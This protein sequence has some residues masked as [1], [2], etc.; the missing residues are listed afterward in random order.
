MD[1]ASGTED[2][3]NEQIKQQQKPKV[4]GRGRRPEKKIV[5]KE[6]PKFLQEPKDS[7]TGVLTRSQQRYQ[8]TEVDYDYEFVD[9]HSHQTPV[10]KNLFGTDVSMNSNKKHNA[11]LLAERAAINIQALRT[12]AMKQET[13][14]D[15]LAFCAKWHLDPDSFNHEQEVKDVSDS[16]KKT[17]K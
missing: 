14:E 10:G 11:L 13:R 4:R 16:P 3:N 15:F 5:Q 2:N 7:R 8:P 1:D 12:A 9:N 17:N 6:V